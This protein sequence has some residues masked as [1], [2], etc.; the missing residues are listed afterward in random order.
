VLPRHYFDKNG[1]VNDLR[2]C[3]GRFFLDPSWCGK[4]F[5]R[6][7]W[8]TARLGLEVW[9]PKTVMLAMNSDANCLSGDLLIRPKSV[10]RRSNGLK[11]YK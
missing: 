1:I 8:R 11:R 7:G 3:G 4:R 10:K 2:E 6:M 5:P 9:L